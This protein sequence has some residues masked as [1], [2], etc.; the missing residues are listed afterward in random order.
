A[1]IGFN[2]VF[3]LTPEDDNLGEDTFGKLLESLEALPD[4]QGWTLPEPGLLT[5]LGIG[6]YTEYQGEAIDITD[7]A[8][9]GINLAEKDAGKLLFSYGAV[10]VDRE[11][12]DISTEGYPLLVSDEEELIWNDGAADDVIIAQW[13]IGKTDVSTD[14]DAEDIWLAGYANP[15]LGVWQSDIPS[16][17]ATLT[18][19]FKPDATFDYELS[20]VPADQG[21]VGSGGYIVSRNVMVSFLAFEG[22]AGYVFE[23]VDNDTIDVTEIID[24]VE[25]EPVLGETAPFAR[26]EGSEPPSEDLPFKLDNP[27]V[28]LWEAE[29]PNDENPDEL[30]SVLM[31]YKDD[32]TG[33]FTLKPD[34]VFP[35]ARY[36][37]SDNYLVTYSPWETAYEMFSFTVLDDQTIEATEVLAILPDGAVEYGATALFNRVSESE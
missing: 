26:V 8:S 19:S 9:Y 16:A 21:G 15:F 25:G 6:V 12:A 34:M 28:G 18:F 37:V 23:V 4:Y 22:A 14:A 20:N 30:F 36:F 32:G 10:M 35:E 11:I 13:W 5:S 33:L 7:R 3:Y 29:L 1:A 27:F 17:D 24:V 31:E 2:S